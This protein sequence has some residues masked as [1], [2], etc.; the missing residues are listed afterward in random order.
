MLVMMCN[1][2]RAYAILGR[3]NCMFTTDT[4]VYSAS[5]IHRYAH[6]YIYILLYFSLPTD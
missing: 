3:G 5:Y 6:A 2:S 4:M 1:I